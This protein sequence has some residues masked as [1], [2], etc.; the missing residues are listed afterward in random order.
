MRVMRLNDLRGVCPKCKA[1]MGV[2]P[3][4]MT[5]ESGADLEAPPA[6]W[7]GAEGI[8]EPD[9]E[10]D[11]CAGCAKAVKTHVDNAGVEYTA[12]D[13]KAGFVPKARCCGGD[14]YRNGLCFRC[15]VEARY[16]QEEARR[17]RDRG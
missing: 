1:T 6:G 14:L 9:P 11:L 3:V 7:V 15:Y 8:V 5:Y 12:D 13:V 16:E 2:N 4:S 10:T 17:N